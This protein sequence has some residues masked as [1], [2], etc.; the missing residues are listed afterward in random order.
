MLKKELLGK[1]LFLTQPDLDRYL[2]KKGILKT[3][4]G[5]YLDPV[6][7]IIVTSQM[8]GLPGSFINNATIKK[9]YF[10]NVVKTAT[11][12]RK[13][14]GIFHE[15]SLFSSAKNISGF[16]TYFNSQNTHLTKV[17]NSLL[18]D[19]FIE[20]QTKN[21]N[22]IKVKE[23]ERD[24]KLVNKMLA[25]ATGLGLNAETTKL[26]LS[27][28]NIFLDDNKI[29]IGNSV[30]N[31]IHEISGT[32]TENFQFGNDDRREEL[33]RLN[34]NELELI[35]SAINCR[36][37]SV[38][39]SEVDLDNILPFIPEGYADH[40][41]LE[42]FFGNEETAEGDTYNYLPSLFNSKNEKEYLYKKRKKKKKKGGEDGKLKGKKGRFRK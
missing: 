17:Q 13:R 37:F 7:K 34:D 4:Q 5:T 2:S 8:L 21:I 36:P 25:Y 10:A 19:S 23:N 26:L 18:L 28:F 1:Y 41:H 27:K 30:D 16:T 32:D 20:Y 42:E 11:E 6:N 33:N 29:R 40:Y 15:S 24:I 3:G 22:R 38:D 31:V 14:A 39:R 12:Y 35:R 9:E